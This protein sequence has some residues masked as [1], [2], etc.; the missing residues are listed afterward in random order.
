MSGESDECE[1][2]EV[3]EETSE[4]YDLK[5]LCALIGSKKTLLIFYL[6]QE[7]LRTRRDVATKL[8]GKTWKWL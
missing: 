4:I 1:N 7:F 5:D 3:D 2:V 6:K 8:V